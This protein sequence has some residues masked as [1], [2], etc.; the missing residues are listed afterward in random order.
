[1]LSFLVVLTVGSF[2][3]LDIFRG[4]AGFLFDLAVLVAIRFLPSGAVLYQEGS[5][6]TANALTCRK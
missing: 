1:V 5:V 4:F 3:A 2:V 6:L